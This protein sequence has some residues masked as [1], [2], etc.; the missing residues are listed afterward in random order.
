MGDMALLARRRGD[1]KRHFFLFLRSFA[2]TNM[3]LSKQAFRAATERAIYNALPSSPHTITIIY[4][5]P[6]S[7]IP[8]FSVAIQYSILSSIVDSFRESYS[9]D[10]P[11]YHHHRT[12][13]STYLPCQYLDRCLP[14][15]GDR[16]GSVGVG[17]FPKKAG[18]QKQAGTFRQ[19]KDIKALYTAPFC[20]TLALP[21]HSARAGSPLLPS[22]DHL[23]TYNTTMTTAYP[24]L[25][26]PHPTLPSPF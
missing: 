11:I 18:F 10:R 26:P 7:T 20:F 17:W 16:F 21:F 14:Q 1:S 19:N 3:C 24:V 6:F 5:S 4:D 9:S 25:P 2:P 13:S 22:K 12:G 23:H 15:Q 8:S